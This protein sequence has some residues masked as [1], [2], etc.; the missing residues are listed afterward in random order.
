MQ[1]DPN[2]SSGYLFLGAS[3]QYVG[4]KEEAVAMIEKAIRLNPIPPSAY[5]VFQGSALYNA[6]RYDQAVAA[7]RKAL[8][9]SPN[10]NFAHLALVVAYSLAGREAEA[11]S[12]AAEVLRIQP[13]FSVDSLA[14]RLPYKDPADVE[15]LVNAQRKAGL[16]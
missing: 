2:L 15:R 12:A 10:N 6:G 1:L 13:N 16:K 11:R 4:R 5:Y 3:L 9:L 7:A 8:E 14:K